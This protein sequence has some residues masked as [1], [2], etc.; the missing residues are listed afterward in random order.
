M[1]TGYN[2]M[3]YANVLMNVVDDSRIIGMRMFYFIRE[4]IRENEVRQARITKKNY[5]LCGAAGACVAK[6]RVKFPPET[7]ICRSDSLCFQKV[8]IPFYVVLKYASRL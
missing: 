4:I 7:T 8:K 3:M 6:L 5:D 2:Y 1:R